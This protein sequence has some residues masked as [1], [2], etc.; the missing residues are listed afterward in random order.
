V[1]GEKRGGDV[2][3]RGL[4]DVGRNDEKRRKRVI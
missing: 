4:G 3:R 1:R 2:E